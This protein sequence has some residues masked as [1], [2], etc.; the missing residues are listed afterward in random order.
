VLS[1]LGGTGCDTHGGHRSSHERLDREG[2]A[3]KMM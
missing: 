1:A 2:R 3:G